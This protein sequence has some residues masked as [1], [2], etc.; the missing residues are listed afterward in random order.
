MPRLHPAPPAPPRRGVP[1]R[2]R[3]VGRR[4]AQPRGRDRAAPEPPT[5]PATAAGRRARLAGS[6]PVY[7]RPAVG[8]GTDRCSPSAAL[9][10]P[11]VAKTLRPHPR[12]LVVDNASAGRD[13]LTDG[14][15][16]SGCRIMLN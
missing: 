13:R 3:S 12:H 16:R 5:Q 2:R 15:H 7:P 9:S 8:A 14:D 6:S 10:G 1:Q 11:L 4:I